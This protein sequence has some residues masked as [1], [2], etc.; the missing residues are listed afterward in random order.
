MEGEANAYYNNPSINLDLSEQDI[1]SCANAGDC[2]GG[3]S[4]YA[5]SYAMSTGVTSESCFPYT[6]TNN[7]CSNK[8]L[9]WQSNAWK[10]SNYDDDP[11]PS[12]NTINTT[13]AKIVQQGPVATYF[14]VYDDFFSYEGG[15]YQPTSTDVAGAH[16][17][18]I[19]GYGV[20]STNN[21]TYWI[22]KNSWGSDWGESGFFRIYAGVSN[23]GQEIMAITSPNPP[24]PQKT[25]CEDKDKDGYCNW[26][27]GLKPATG[28]PSSCAKQVIEDCDDANAKVGASCSKSCVPMWTCGDWSACTKS[29]QTRTCTDSNKCGVKDNEPPLKQSCAL[30][31]YYPFR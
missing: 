23:I 8:C 19:I 20:D 30:V 29:Q 1:V 9:T 11:A 15:I 22:C 18:A 4:S 24:K 25:I 3:L 27:L 2:S 21:K 31:A 28:C 5:L 10:I 12:S 6:S 13:E 16:A 14:T 17:V 7:S 26:G